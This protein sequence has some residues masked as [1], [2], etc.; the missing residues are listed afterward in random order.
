MPDSVGTYYMIRRSGRPARQN[1]SPV[2]QGLVV[3]LGAVVTLAAGCAPSDSGHEPQGG[4]DSSDPP[5]SRATLL[6]EGARLIVGD[7]SVIEAAAFVIEGGQILEVGEVGEV[8]EVTE[9]WGVTLI[10][11]SGKTVIPALIDL[12][13][14]IHQ[15]QQAREV[16]GA[17]FLFAAGMGP[18]GQGPNN[19]FLGHALA[20]ADATGMTVLR[21]AASEEEGRRAVREVAATEVPF[22][23]IWLDDRGGTQEKLQ[24]EIYRAIL[25]EATAH[26]IEVF[27]HQQS[28]E[29]MPDLL[30][31]G[32]AG[33]LHG[34]MGPDLDENL[35]AQIRDSGAFLVPNLGLGELRRERVG[36]DPFLREATL[37]EVAERLGQAYDTRQAESGSSQA[38]AAGATERERELREAFSRPMRAIVSATSRPAERLGLSELGTIATGMSADFIVLDANPLEDIRNTRAISQVYLQGHEVHREGLRSRWTGAD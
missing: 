32:A 21:G 5:E 30:D 13:W 3:T 16:G 15:A 9:D 1:K 27:V 34:R 8:G 6:F 18:P 35:A 11:L 2:S 33:F 24:P 31:A 25:D 29:D 20:I 12:A 19:Q 14:E 7:G 23:K 4:V 38:A 22:I 28:A 37:P 17:R 10:D 36:D 26:G